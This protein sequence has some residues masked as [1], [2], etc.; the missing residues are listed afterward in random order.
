MSHSWET[1]SKWSETDTPSKW[2]Y[3]LQNSGELES[4][5]EIFKMT[6]VPQDPVWHP[7]GTVFIHTCYVLDAAADIAI[8]EKLSPDSRELLIFSALAHD[9]GKVRATFLKNGRWTSPKHGLYSTN[10]AKKFLHQIG[11]PNELLHSKL[12]KLVIEH[13]SYINVETD[14]ALLHL[15]ERLKPASI[16]ELIW[17]IEADVSGRPPLPKVLPEQAKKLK[18]RSLELGVYS[19]G[20]VAL[21]T[22]NMLSEYGLPKPQ[23]AALIGQAY[24]AQLSGT[25]LD[26]KAALVWVRGQIFK[27]L[28]NGRLIIDGGILPPCKKVGKLLDDAKIAQ[29]QGRFS[30]LDGA[31]LWAKQWAAESNK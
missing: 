17:L 29:N 1:W 11:C 12:E 2:L 31:L 5:P 23:M 13:L 7:E 15:A 30:D 14:K 4:Y 27:P 9:F 26:E 25:F 22:E 19:R 16:E 24:A 21:I 8:R 18:A 6:G 20:P 3:E 28:L 10:G